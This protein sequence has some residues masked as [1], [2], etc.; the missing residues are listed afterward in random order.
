MKGTQVRTGVLLSLGMIGSLSWYLVATTESPRTFTAVES[1][2]AVTSSASPSISTAP[3]YLNSPSAEV[4]P[5]TDRLVG[6]QVT[7]NTARAVTVSWE[8]TPGAQHYRVM[9]GSS[10]IGTV[11][12]TSAVVLWNAQPALEITIMPVGESGETGIPAS[13]E[14]AAPRGRT[15]VERRHPEP[16]A[17]VQPRQPAPSDSNRPQP[18][19]A[20]TPDPVQS[21]EPGE[22]PASEEPA[23]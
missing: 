23:G 19:P 18:Q 16:G 2:I 3:L 1:T 8:I 12:R 14:V 4:S 10:V 17:S 5:T 21:Q 6:L 11:E 22:P 7:Q 13:I 15:P 20:P 9:A